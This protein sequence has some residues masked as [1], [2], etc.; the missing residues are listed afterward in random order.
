MSV[1]ETNTSASSSI[2]R[3]LDLVGDRWT[4][5]ILR[6]I[7]RGVRRFGE[8]QTDLGIARNLLADR[9]AKLVDAGILCKVAYQDRPLRHDYC[10]TAKGQALSPS[11]V[12]LMRWGD[13]WC[14]DGEA[15]TLL[16][17]A[18][19]GTPLEQVTRCPT[20]DDPIS[21]SA[22]RSRPGPGAT[23]TSS[24]DTPRSHTSAA[25]RTSTSE[26]MEPS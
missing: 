22:I 2:Q 24:S 8:I 13:E 25:D 6:D 4:F 26:N 23:A 19:C 17:H 21:P 18:E 14:S 10:L 16:V 7:F 5:L 20:C 15:P 11:L 1:G 9:L 3:T 12:A